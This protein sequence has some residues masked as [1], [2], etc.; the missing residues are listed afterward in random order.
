MDPE[1]LLFD[2]PTSAL[3][4]EM[5]G[6]VLDLIK[7]IAREGMTMIV[8][9]HEMGF[10]KDISSRVIFMDDG[11]IAVEGTPEE[12][13]ENSTNERIVKFLNSVTK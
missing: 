12:V 11:V 3:D 5:V 10:A 13:F 2:E 9:T 6:E 4:P 8:V 7:E 1:V